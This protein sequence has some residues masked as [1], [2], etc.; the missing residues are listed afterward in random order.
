MEAIIRYDRGVGSVSNGDQV[1]E[2][3]FCQLDQRFSYI[4]IFQ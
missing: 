2:R 3:A 1:L 4:P